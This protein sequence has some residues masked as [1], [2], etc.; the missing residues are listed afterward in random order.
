MGG[1]LAEI[2]SRAEQDSLYHHIAHLAGISAT[3]TS[4]ADGGGIAYVWLGAT[5]KFAEGSWKWDG[6]NSGSGTSLWTGQGSAGAGGGSA[7]GSAFINWGGSSHG[8]AS[9]PDNY[10]GIQNAAGIALSAWPYGIAGEWN[11]I[12]PANQLYFVV[13][14]DGITEV[15]VTDHNTW[16]NIYPD[17][18]AGAFNVNSNATINAITVYDMMGKNCRTIPVDHASSCT[19]QIN[20]LSLG[21]YIVRVAFADGSVIVRRIVH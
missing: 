9:E 21:Q 17:L 10:G 20:D 16:L 3:Y 18:A 13:E 11:D 12:D 2:G 7:V 6:R 14:Y 4:V 19:V 15:P 1:H 5:D 8:A